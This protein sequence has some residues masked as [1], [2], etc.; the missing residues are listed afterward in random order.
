MTSGILYKLSYKTKFTSLSEEPE[1]FPTLNKFHCIILAQKYFIPK[2]HWNVKLRKLKIFELT[3]KKKER[4]SC[5]KHTTDAKFSSV[6][7]GLLGIE[8]KRR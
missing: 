7:V 4:G 6:C 3:T 5:G 2:P 8:I 1:N